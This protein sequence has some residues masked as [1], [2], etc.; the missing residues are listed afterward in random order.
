VY[1]SHSR[2]L[3]NARIE[4]RPTRPALAM[5]TYLAVPAEG[6]PAWLKSADP[7]LPR[8]GFVIAASPECV[9]VGAAIPR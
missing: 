6:R 1:E 4:F 2:V 5:T 7:G 9:L 3:H 8:S